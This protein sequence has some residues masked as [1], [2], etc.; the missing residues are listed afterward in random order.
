MYVLYEVKKEV[1]ER[2]R[3]RT[4]ACPVVVLREVSISACWLASAHWFAAY[5]KKEFSKKYRN[6]KDMFSKK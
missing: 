2:G 5:N 1:K 4:A 6:N 3:E